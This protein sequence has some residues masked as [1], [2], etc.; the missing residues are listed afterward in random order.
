MRF[1]LQ[2]KFDIAKLRGIVAASQDDRE[3][4]GEGH[5]RPEYRTLF[6]PAGYHRGK[7]RPLTPSM[8]KSPRMNPS[9][10]Y[11]TAPAW[12]ARGKAVAFL[13]SVTAMWECSSRIISLAVRVLRTK[14]S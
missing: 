2:K 4:A 7:D 9:D 14:S 6:A 8:L 12:V 3:L 1:K 13:I 10:R 5:G 11:L